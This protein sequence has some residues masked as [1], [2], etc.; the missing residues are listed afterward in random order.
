MIHSPS[1]W[2]P[3]NKS[4]RRNPHL[5]A[6]PVHGG[7]G[8][9]LMTDPQRG[10][11][12]RGGDNHPDRRIIITDMASFGKIKHS[13]SFCFYLISRRDE[14]DWHFGPG[15]PGIRDLKKREFW[16]LPG[17]RA[18]I[19]VPGMVVLQPAPLQTVNRTLYVPFAVKVW[20]TWG[21]TPVVLNQVPS[22]K[23]QFRRL[24]PVPVD[25]SPKFTDSGITPLLTFFV[26]MATGKPVV[27]TV[28]V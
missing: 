3:W 25:R 17:Y 10:A 15:N 1:N 2:E 4:G 28:T 14:S 9:L 18:V 21:M 26:I 12:V 20:I 8:G 6:F 13:L 22:P 19:L 16:F 24:I 5:R 7:K 27:V 23:L 11:L